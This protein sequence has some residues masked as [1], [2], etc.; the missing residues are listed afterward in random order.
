VGWD[1]AS[2]KSTQNPPTGSPDLPTRNDEARP[3]YYCA[4][5]A[6][7]SRLEYYSYCG[8]LVREVA[9]ARIKYLS[10]LWDVDGGE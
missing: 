3:N 5:H 10:R 1:D 9:V 2:T 8:I 4:L 6:R 7:K